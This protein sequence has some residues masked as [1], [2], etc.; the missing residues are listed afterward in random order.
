MANPYI[1]VVRIL[2]ALLAAGLLMAIVVAA[3]F[4]LASLDHHPKDH[5]FMVWQREVQNA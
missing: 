3:A 4:Y 2:K 5:R 1:A